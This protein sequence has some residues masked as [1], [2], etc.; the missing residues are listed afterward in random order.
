MVHGEKMKEIQKNSQEIIRIEN[1]EYKGNKF[2]DVRVYYK[3]RDT[4]EY[5]P[6]KKGISFNHR[7]AKEVIEALLEEMEQESWDNFETN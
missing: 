1:K 6:T 7:I 2:L 3:D 5:K 4:E